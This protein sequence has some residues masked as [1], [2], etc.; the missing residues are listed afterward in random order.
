MAFPR[1]GITL[2]SIRFIKIKIFLGKKWNFFKNFGKLSEPK[3]REILK[4]Y[5]EK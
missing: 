2:G 3:K 5:L 4:K 1:K